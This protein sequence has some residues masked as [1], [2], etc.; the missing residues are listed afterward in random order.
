MWLNVFTWAK[1]SSEMRP[2]HSMQSSRGL[3]GLATSAHLISIRLINRRFS[4]ELRILA[5]PSQSLPSLCFTCRSAVV[6]FHSYI[7]YVQYGNT[8]TC[9]LHWSSSPQWHSWVYW[10]CLRTYWRVQSVESFLLPT[11]CQLWPAVGSETESWILRGWESLVLEQC[12][13][14]KMYD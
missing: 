5:C 12:E 9:V 1:Y 14:C 6:R 2:A 11:P 13:S 7:Q 8:V 10:C 3:Q 4:G